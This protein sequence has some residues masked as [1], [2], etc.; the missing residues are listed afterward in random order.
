VIVDFWAE[1]C[2]PCK[3]LGPMLERLVTAARGAVKLVKVD[4]DKNQ[5]IAQQLRI[6]SIPAVYAFY[7]GRPVDAF[8]GALPES[9]LKAF[10][11]KLTKTAGTEQKSPVDEA[12]EQ[13]KALMDA[14]DVAQ[15]GAVYGQIVQHAPDNLAAKAGLAR[16]LVETGEVA[17]A[18][19]IVDGLSDE[20]RADAAF[21]PVIS[22]LELAEKASDAGAAPRRRRGG[23][24]QP[25]DALRSGAR[26]LCGG[27]T[28]RRGRG[29]ARDHPP[30]PGLERRCRAQTA[31]PVF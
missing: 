22:A 1:W 13:A 28:R 5:H 18:K 3:Q 7:Q 4:I 15:A 19:E 29:A 20:E 14:G 25:C 26:A 23:S 24:R 11:D 31:A 8:Q 27:R 21:G 16:C 12:L 2:G 6:Q 9:Q 10:I 30:R 17:K